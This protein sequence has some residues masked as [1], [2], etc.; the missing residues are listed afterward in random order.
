M[1]TTPLT[2]PAGA[3]GVINA[4]T[5]EVRRRALWSACVAHAL[6]DGYTDLI[7]VLLPVWQA[8]FG[9]SYEALAVLRAGY[10]A[11]MAG[12]QW[13]AGRLAERYGGRAVLIAGTVLAALGYVLAGF[14]GTLV[15]LCAALAISGGG[16][17]TQHPIASGSVSRAY[18][19]SA[20]GPLGIYNFSGDLGKALFPA[21]VSFLLILMTW[22]HALWI[23]SAVGIGVAVGLVVFLP[24]SK[25]HPSSDVVAN[26]GVGAARS[27]FPI[28]FAIGVLDTAVRMGLLMFLPF[29]LKAKGA[30]LSVIGLSLSLLFF[31]GA[32]GKFICGW[33]GAR[34]G[35]IRTVFATESATAACILAVLFSPL[36]V[37]VPL[38]PVLGLMLNG[39]SSVLYGT[40]PDLAPPHRTE[41]AFALFYSGVLGSGAIAPLLF[42]AMGDWLGV[43]DATVATALTA[44]AVLPLAMALAPHLRTLR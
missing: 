17:S 26:D 38:L 20:R 6:H 33:L 15:G 5:I 12:L 36:A 41:R 16:S 22:R 32:A 8:E 23:M 19:K 3:V 18:G 40:V 39:T 35:V 28:L 10:A 27:G 9:L 4:P 30:S 2:S 21:A 25:T 43:R 42:G 29:L 7:Y 24:K 44:L 1:K 37:T 13:P 34:A 31:G 14:S 11:T